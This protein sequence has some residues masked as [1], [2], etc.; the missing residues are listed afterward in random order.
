M[1]KNSKIY[2]VAIFCGLIT[3]VTTSWGVQ[4]ENRPL[5]PTSSK[6]QSR[7]PAEAGLES[8]RYQEINIEDLEDWEQR[9]NQNQENSP[10]S[11]KENPAKVESNFPSPSLGR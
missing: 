7:S 11:P 10:T 5:L 2:S 6:S 9:Q 4:I 3:A 8:G 1:A